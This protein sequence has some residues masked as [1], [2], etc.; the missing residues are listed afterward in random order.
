MASPEET[1]PAVTRKPNSESLPPV[2]SA[3]LAAAAETASKPLETTRITASRPA[4]ATMASATR[5]ETESA[6][7]RAASAM[8]SPLDA[9]ERASRARRLFP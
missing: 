5:L 1:L 2:A 3:D 4:P 6:E 8:E 9:V 7:R